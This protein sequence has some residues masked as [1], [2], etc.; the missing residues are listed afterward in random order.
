MGSLLYWKSFIVLSNNRCFEPPNSRNAARSLYC[1]I[2]CPNFAQSFRL[3]LSLPPSLSCS[4]L[5]EEGTSE[6]SGGYPQN[7]LGGAKSC[8]LFVYSSA[9]SRVFFFMLVIKTGFGGTSN[10]FYEY[11]QRVLGVSAATFKG[12]GQIFLL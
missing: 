1:W 5:P 6:R 12:T 9:F 10:A 4:S 2:W 11:Q 7:T 3:G 8:R